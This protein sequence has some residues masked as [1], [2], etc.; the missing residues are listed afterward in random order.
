M[1]KA[2]YQATEPMKIDS[3]GKPA[4]MK[5]EEA[6]VKMKAKP[7]EVNVDAMIDELVA[8]AN[9]ALAEYMEMD[10]V[11]AIFHLIFIRHKFFYKI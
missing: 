3:V 1:A 2:E 7:V 6:A 4:V 5:T 8:N 10:Q 11:Q 9:Q